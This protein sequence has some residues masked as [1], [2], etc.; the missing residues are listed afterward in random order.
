MA[1]EQMRFRGSL[2]SWP[3][4]VPDAPTGQQTLENTSYVAGGTAL[5]AF[6]RTMVTDHGKGEVGPR[7]QLFRVDDTFEVPFWSIW[8]QGP[9]PDVHNNKTVSSKAKQMQTAAHDSSF[10]R[11]FFITKNSY[12]GM[13]PRNMQQGD[14]IH[15]AAGGNCPLVL[16]PVNNPQS[17]STNPRYT[18]VGDCYL[19]GIMDGEAANNFEKRAT[20]VEII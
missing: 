16:R 5:N 7:S 19:H 10:G 12:F 18:L 20:M 6:W 15:V 4:Y 14:E 13:G 3:S 9:G 8:N 11:R 1:H 17:P 2:W